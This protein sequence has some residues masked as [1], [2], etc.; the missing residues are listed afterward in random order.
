LGA[1]VFQSLPGQNTGEAV[2]SSLN[3][4]DGGAPGWLALLDNSAAAWAAQH[5]R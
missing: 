5:S 2:A 4:G 3:A 1:A